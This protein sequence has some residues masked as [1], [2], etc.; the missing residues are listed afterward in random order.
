MTNPTQKPPIQVLWFKKDLRLFDHAPLKEAIDQH[1]PLLL[2]YIF[3]P[4][5]QKY[6]DW[7][8]RHWQ[9]IYQSIRQINEKLKNFNTQIHCFCA[10]TQ[11][12]FDYILEQYHIKTV[13][14]HQ[15]TGVRLTY[16]RDLQIQ[17]FFEKNQIS[18]KEYQ[19]NGIIRGQKDRSSWD[20][21]W[22]DYV[23]SPIQILI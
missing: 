9:F 8:I 13:F 18:W 3:E 6:P 2:I 12:V 17:K 14:S 15:E 23:E 7:N 21:A 10:E 11:P 20:K 16:D 19:N 5:L 22:I 1:L 4:S